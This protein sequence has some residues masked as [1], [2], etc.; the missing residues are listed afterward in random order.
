VN[1]DVLGRDFDELETGDA[2]RTGGRTITESDLVSFAALTGDWHPQHADAA[3][4][5]RSEFGERIAHGMLVLSF[6]VGLAP[7]DPDRVA[8]LRGVDDVTFKRPVRIGDT[9][10]VEGRVEE[11][12]PLGDDAGLVTCLWR[13]VN[14]AGELAVRARVT[15]VWR[16]R[17]AGAPTNGSA[18][19]SRERQGRERLF[20]EVYL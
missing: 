14:Q 10:H 3:W 20:D 5:A 9:I 2:F 6:A 13:V 7:I 16:R 4:A 11:L 18:G 12:R 15:I 8:A 1:D 19:G 17:G